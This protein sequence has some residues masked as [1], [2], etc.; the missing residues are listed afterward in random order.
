MQAANASIS[1]RVNPSEY[2]SVRTSAIP[3]KASGGMYRN[4]PRIS[5]PPVKLLSPIAFA[6]PEVGDPDR[7]L[8]VSSNRLAGLNVPVQHSLLVSVLNPPRRSAGRCE[9]RFSCQYVCFRRSWRRIGIATQT[10]Q[11]RYRPWPPENELKAFPIC[12]RRHSR[13]MRVARSGSESVVSRRALREDFS[14]RAASSRLVPSHV[15]VER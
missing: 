15:W 7:T 12:S 11:A 10:L 6:S 14:R 5:P 1:Y 9:R 4:V 13:F 3:L 8:D 2:T